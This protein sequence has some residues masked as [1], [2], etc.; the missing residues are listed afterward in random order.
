VLIDA[1]IYC[2]VDCITNLSEDVK[3]IKALKK[4]DAKV[5][6]VGV[7]NTLDG[8]TTEIGGQKYEFGEIASYGFKMLNT[9]IKAMDENSD[10]YYYVDVQDNIET[11]MNQLVMSESYEELTST[12]EGNSVM[13]KFYHGGDSFYDLFLRGNEWSSD[14]DDDPGSFLNQFREP[15]KKLLYRGAKKVDLHMDELMA[16]LANLYSPTGIG[17]EIALYFTAVGGYRNIPSSYPGVYDSLTDAQK[18]EIT[19]YFVDQKMQNKSDNDAM[20]AAITG[21]AFHN[22]AFSNDDN[23]AIAQSCAYWG[24]TAD[25]AD[26]DEAAAGIGVTADKKDEIPSFP[27]ESSME[28]MQILDRFIVYQGIGQHPSKDGCESMFQDVKTAYIKSQTGGNTAYGDFK[29]D[30]EAL[31]AQYRKMF[32][33]T[34]LGD[35]IDNLVEMKDHIQELMPLIDEAMP[36]LERMDEILALMDRAEKTMDE[37]DDYKAKLN[38]F[39]GFYKQVLN[40][41]GVSEEDVIQNAKLITEDIDAETVAGWIKQI[42]DIAQKYPELRDKYE[43]LIRDYAED[44]LDLVDKTMDTLIKQKEFLDENGIEIDWEQVKRVIIKM[45]DFIKEMPDLYEKYQPIFQKDAKEILDMIEKA[46]DT[47]K[48]Q[49]EFLEENGIEIDMRQVADAIVAMNDLIKAFP[50][51]KAKYE[52]LIREYASDIYEIIDKTVKE[53]VKNKEMIEDAIDV[54]KIAEFI[55][56]AKDVM[57]IVKDVYN[58]MPTQQEIMERVRAEINKQLDKVQEIV[59]AKAAEISEELLAKIKE[60]SDMIKDATDGKDFDEIIEELQPLFEELKEIGLAV[61]QLPEYEKLIDS[62]AGVIDEL[63]EAAANL[64]IDVATLSDQAAELQEQADALQSKVGE[65]EGELAKFQEQVD[66]D[67]EL[68][69]KLKAKSISV[70]IKTKV[71]FPKNKAKLTVTWKKDDDAAGYKLVVNGEQKEFTETATG[72]QYVDTT[73]QIG[74]TYKIEITP[75]ATYGRLAAS[76]KTF[77]KS[78]KPKVTLK[79]AV[80]KKVKAGKNKVTVKWKKVSGASGYKISYKVGKNKTRYKTIKGGKKI[81]ATIKKLTSGKK[82]KVKVRA[83]KKVNGKKYYGKWSKAKTVKVK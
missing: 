47:L 6:V 14:P 33:G 44:I 72:F 60:I 3:M 20:T 40:A 2:Y 76:G 21:F 27:S 74:E 57:K 28:L 54:E 51:M 25:G 24:T 50:E 79:K 17:A 38:E 49:K 8:I 63:S 66:Q 70:S 53:I 64:Q 68:I 77:E 32:E 45:N 48:A 69:A 46:I 26:E 80:I 1:F 10:F 65:L 39:Y 29:D 18:V 75:S 23:K 43:P 30:L 9:H 83:W 15:A 81:K 37:V 16:N 58:N 55:R 78:V 61:Y 82:C 12:P 5:I 19:S 11:F 73:V 35:D 34:P 41:L 56:T 22:Y 4:D 71:T 67:A 59:E 42:Y 36:L 52:P 62:Y 13:D 7:Y 31:F